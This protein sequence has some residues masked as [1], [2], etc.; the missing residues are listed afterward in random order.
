MPLPVRAF[1][2]LDDAV[3][4][5]ACPAEASSEACHSDSRVRSGDP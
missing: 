2:L 1:I 3:D 5:F 4:R